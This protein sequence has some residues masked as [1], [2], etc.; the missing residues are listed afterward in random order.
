MRSVL[1][2][3]PALALPACGS[4][5][6]DDTPFFDDGGDATAQGEGGG[7]GDASG[8]SCAACA[9]GQACVQL[10]G[11]SP[12]VYVC[13]GPGCGRPSSDGGG[14][15]TGSECEAVT[16]NPCPPP[17]PGQAQCNIAS[18]TYQACVAVAGVGDAGQSE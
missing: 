12:V 4:T 9:P 1:A 15:P 13:A 18:I 11:S 10:A 6:V 5:T 14:C 16:T 17:M 2:V 8:G 3:L 7:G